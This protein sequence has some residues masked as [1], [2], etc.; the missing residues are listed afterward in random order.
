MYTHTALR[1]VSRTSRFIL[2]LDLEGL[3]ASFMFHREALHIYYGSRSLPKTLFS[4]RTSHDR[5]HTFIDLWN[6]VN[7]SWSHKFSAM[8]GYK[9]VEFSPDVKW[10]NELILTASAV[11]YI[12]WILAIVVPD[13]VILSMA[14]VS[15]FD[16]IPCLSFSCHILN[17]RCSFRSHCS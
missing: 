13:F 8:E 11:N 16:A 7:E 2:L 1:Q 14:Y 15:N 9:D 4:C 3:C 12:T 6:T 17:P 10:L 5:Y